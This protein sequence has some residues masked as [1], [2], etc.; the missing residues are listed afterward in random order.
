[1]ALAKPDI[2]N[3][4]EKELNCSKKEAV[5]IAEALLEIV[6]ADLEAGNDVLVSGF[7]KF[8]VKKKNGRKGR[9]PATGEDMMLKKRRGVVFKCSGRL[10]ATL[11]G[12]P[13][14]KRF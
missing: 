11:N 2:S 12:K 10:R 9:N 14:S 3:L 6:N 4:L 13:D 8:C 1:M 5:S 7:G